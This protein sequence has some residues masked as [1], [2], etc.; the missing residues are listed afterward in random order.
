[1]VSLQ[2]PQ[3]KWKH[4]L[5]PKACMQYLQSSI[6]HFLGFM[7]SSSN[8]YFYVFSIFII[9][10]WSSSWTDISSIPLIGTDSS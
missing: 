7:L 10:L 6:A 2:Y 5:Q 4:N 1:M 8:T 9:I 3:D